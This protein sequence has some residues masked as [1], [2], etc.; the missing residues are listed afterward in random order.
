MNNKLDWSNSSFKQLE[1]FSMTN[2][3]K[4]EKLI[5]HTLE[6][7]LDMKNIENMFDFPLLQ[8]LNLS[9]FYYYGRCNDLIRKIMQ[10]RQK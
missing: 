7:T 10:N 4:L 1:Y 9:S 3:K 2:W 5:I 6:K 8:K